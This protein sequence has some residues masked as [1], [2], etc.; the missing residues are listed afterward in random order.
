MVGTEEVFL[1]CGG[2]GD[3]IKNRV[4]G[5]L[6]SGDGG[7]CFDGGGGL[8]EDDGLMIVEIFEHGGG[9]FFVD[10]EFVDLSFGEILAV[11]GALGVGYLLNDFGE[12]CGVFGL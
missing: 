3:S 11:R 12:F 10:G 6:P 4:E 1:G 2:V 5:G 9:A 7:F 8:F